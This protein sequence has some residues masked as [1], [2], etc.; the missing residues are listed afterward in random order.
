MEFSLVFWRPDET[1][2]LLFCFP[3]GPFLLRKYASSQAFFFENTY[4]RKIFVKIE[5]I[6]KIL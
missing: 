6:A 2:A 4:T 5:K 3:N 1:A